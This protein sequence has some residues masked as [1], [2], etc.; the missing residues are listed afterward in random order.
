MLIVHR[1][2]W[3][4]EIKNHVDFN[5]QRKADVVAH[6]LEARISSQM[7]KVALI[8][9]EQIIDAQDFIAPSVLY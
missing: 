4:G 8:A 3:T 2:R 5:K 1:R 7:V 9:R 6:E